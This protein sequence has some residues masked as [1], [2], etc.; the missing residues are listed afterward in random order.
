MAKRVSQVDGDRIRD[1]LVELIR[2]PSL[3]GQEDPAINRIATWL[4]ESDAEVDYWY[5]GIAAL[6]RNPHYPG[7]EVE[8]SWVPVVAGMVRGARPGPTVLLTGHIDVVPAG[9]YEQW[10]G[11]PFSGLVTGDEVYGRGAADMKAGL[12]AA[13]EAFETFATGSP[14]FP[15]RVI[16]LA[17]PAEEDSGLGTLAA[18]ARGWWADAAILPE[19]TLRGGAPDLVVAHAGAISMRLTIPG[20]AAHASKRREGESAL[21]HFLSIY[22]ALRD[23]EEAINAAETHPLMRDLALPYPTNVGIISG[24]Q[25]SST[26]MDSLQVDVRIGIALD[27]TVDEAE[28]R[29]RRAIDAAIGEDPWLAAHPPTVTRNAAGFG[30]A[31]IPLEH[32]LVTAVADASE[33]VF[34]RR[35]A[36]TAAPYACDMSGWVR[37]A[38][39]PTVLYGPGDIEW[40]HAADETASLDA[41]ERVARVLVEATEQL[42][43]LPPEELRLAGETT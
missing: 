5:D 11:D 23:D 30:S 33:G 24:G 21:E 22:Q 18:I 15:G 41:T 16:F 40:A 17:V 2:I 34:G 42:L 37:L 7:H 20:L 1:R 28:D 35:A 26:V 39:V 25:W 27:E 36:L 13:L 43:E 31:Q 6:Q 32:P 14:D 29:F 19:P 8:R 38:G 12:V 9:D 10:S 3:T 4:Q